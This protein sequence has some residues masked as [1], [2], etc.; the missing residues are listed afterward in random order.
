MNH[1]YRLI[2][3]DMR[4]AYVAVAEI[5]KRRG[6]RAGA[7]VR[8]AAAAIAI[9]GMPLSVYA[10]DTTALP[11]GAQ[12]VAGN[13][14]LNQ[15]GADLTVHQDSQRA[16]LNWTSFDIGSDASV[17]FEQ[18]NSSAVA[19]NRVLGGTTS[20]VLGKLSAN[21]Q[22][23][24][25]NPNGVYFGKGAQVDVGGLVASSLGISDSDFLAGRARFAAAGAAGAVRNEGTIRAQ[26][27]V[28]AMLAPVVGNAGTIRA[29]QVGLAAG[30]Q[31]AL[32]FDQDGLLS[33]AVEKGALQAQI[34][35]SGLIQGNAVLLSARGASA[36]H[37]SVIN[38]DGVIEATDLSA[39]GGRILLD[40]GDNGQVNVSGQ[41]DAS[42]ASGKGGRIDLLGDRLVLDGGARLD[43]SGALGGG[44]IHVGGGWQGH[45]ASLHNAT[46]VDVDN[47]VSV[48]ASASKRGDGGEVVFWSDGSTHFAGRIDITGGAQGGDGGRA[49]VSGKQDLAYSGRTDARATNGATGD[50]LLDPTTLTIQAGVGSGDITGSTVYVSDLEAQT[51]NVML[52]A[53]SGITVADLS[54][55]GGDGHLTMANNVSLRLEN[56]SGTI[57]FANKNNT[58][59][60]FGTG[61]IYMQS[62]RTGSGY[63][64]NVANLVAHGTGTNPATLPTHNVSTPGDGTPGAGSITLYGADGISVG[65]ALTTN[66]GYVRI[67]GDSDNMG[68]GDLTLNSP[69]NTNGGNLYL[70]TGSGAVTLNSDMLL[71]AGRIFFKADG[72]YTTGDKVLNGLLSASGDVNIDTAFTMGGN[73]SIYTDGNINFGAVNVN[74]NTGSGVLVL[75]ANAIDWGSATLQNLSTASMRLEPYDASTSMVLGD[76]SGFAS[77]ATLNKLPGIKNLTIGREDGTGTISVSGDYSFNATGSFE[78]VNRNVDI[79]LGSLSTTGDVILTGDNINIGKA[80]TAR[81]GAGKVTIRQSTASNEL[82]LGSGLSNA[83]IGEV[84]A[85]TLEVG[86]SDGGNLVFDSD[87]STGATTVH[88][89]SGGQVI[90]V[91][92]G[93][94][95]ASLAI[96]AGGGATISDDTFDFTTLGLDVGGDSTITS[97]SSN[98]SLGAVDGLAGLSIQS[99]KTATVALKARDTLGL[100]SSIDFA[101]SGST[102]QATA[103][104]GFGAGSV[105]LGHQSNATVT[106]ALDNS[107]TFSLGGT[108]TVLSSAALTRFNGLDTLNVAAGDID[109]TVDDFDVSVGNR[110][111]IDAGT[112]Q[113][114]GDMQVDTGSLYLNVDQGGLQLDHAVT[115]AQTV[116]LNDTA[117]AGIQGSGVI[118]ADALALR[119]RG[120]VDLDASTHQVGRIAADVGSLSFTNGRTLSV[121]SVDGLDGIE[122]TGAVDVRAAGA[123]S[124]LVLNNAVHAGNSG[125]AQTAVLL[126]AGRNFINHVGATAVSADQGRWLVYSTSPLNDTRGGLAAEFKQYDAG[127]ADTVLDNGSGFLYTVAPTIGVT[128]TGSADKVYDGTDAASSDDIGLSLNGA[129]D[130]D[131]VV[132]NKGTSHYDDKN[133]GSGKTVTMDGLDIGGTSNGSVR[134]Y[135]YTLAS[136]SASGAIGTVT[137]KTI[138]LGAG[139][140]QDKIYDGTT[141]AQLAGS[142][143]LD[144]VI[145]SDSVS[146]DTGSVTFADRNAGTGKLVNVTGVSLAGTDAGNYAV[147]GAT[148]ADIDRRTVTV[149]VAVQDKVY[150]GTTDASLASV[151]PNNLIAGDKVWLDAQAA[152]T[153]KNVGDNKNVVVSATLSGDDAGNYVLDATTANPRASTA[154]ITPKMIDAGTLSVAGKVYDGNRDATV[155]STGPVGVVGGDD[156]S[157]DLTGL[158]DDKNA[159]TGKHVDVSLGLSGGDAGNYRLA[160]TTASSTGDI[161]PKTIDAGTLSVAG[162]VYDGNR[163]ATVHSTGPVGVVGGDDLSLDLTG[164]YDNKN[165]GTGKHVDVSLGLSGGDAGNYRLGSTTASSTG[166]ITRKT[167]DAGTLSVA[168]KVYDGNRDATVHSTGLVGVVGGDDLSLDLT[169]LYDDKN[170]GTGKHVDVSLGLSGGDAGNYQLASTTA[171]STGDITPKSIDAGTVAVVDKRFDG[172]GDATLVL[173]P[174]QGLVDGDDVALQGQG[175]FDTSGTGANKTVQIALSLSGTDAGNYA[176]VN[177]HQQAVAG[178]SDLPGRNAVDAISQSSLGG[179]GTQPG[180]SDTA[181]G[182]SPGAIAAS[183]GAMGDLAGSAQPHLGASSLDPAAVGGVDG[184]GSG[185]AATG[186]GA[187]TLASGGQGA[188]NA[189]A[190]SNG[191]ANDAGHDGAGDGD[192]SDAAGTSAS[193]RDAGDA[194]M[195]QMLRNGDGVTI[196]L[197]GDALAKPRITILPVFTEEGQT[198]DRFRVDDLGDS[199]ALHSV[200]GERDAAPSLEQPVRLRASTQVKVGEKET[201]SLHMELLQDGTLHVVASANAAKLGRDALVAYSLSALRRQAGI[202]PQQV[203]A[204]VLGFTR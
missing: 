156:L 79:S 12:V 117:G 67:W 57:N 168:G 24:L 56:T 84:D 71:G 30:D 195:D 115:A 61:S 3:D 192:A 164:L 55:N 138:S 19:L 178:I 60:V 21:G 182:T 190:N 47:S 107:A 36:L 13:V 124:D 201:A 26:G 11:S 29:D 7:I 80:V 49:E 102:L 4:G 167:I 72:S 106:F 6:K 39:Q 62:G 97:A 152:F 35:Q 177:A 89:K 148:Y 1:T 118:T 16:I 191:V 185:S 88:L 40:G 198:V 133:V 48:D 65:G 163:G 125:A 17:R 14:Q 82:H 140:V 137:K 111:Q 188:D 173:P 132:V 123:S 93:V 159:G 162:K 175:Q 174:L 126:A 45:D 23:W 43:A 160:S 20:Q 169:G 78:L 109:V 53:D 91:A 151:S 121:G 131:T 94:S 193:G 100:G 69:I 204:L 150:D 187:G 85:A 27:G 32:D 157:L 42:S 2:W 76:A 179:N 101:D 66:G 170:A 38:M 59:E 129:I 197:V 64:T 183:T 202:H 127:T 77:A 176:L 74:L 153:D 108:G 135:G 139:S 147:D 8:A 58:I 50:L 165:A 96:T 158:Y 120:T 146:F 98:W 41:L 70:S 203:H 128:L 149:G 87:I 68:G 200:S 172:N 9:G 161:T 99:G 103:G 81:S 155:H 28:V 196:S 112:L 141:A 10:T 143:T 31:V 83:S 92:G 46:R 37:S 63:L 105:V 54:L 22:V 134:V 95:A 181:A 186:A 51:A 73:A 25:V 142:V 104:K 116:A 90:G 86:R 166:D 44:A 52:Q 194:T 145:G 171:S 180:T 136:T 184:G 34:A 113:Q 122:A 110:M 114:L 189:R 199:L 154:S 5:A 18:P 15:H 75:R 130:G 144:G 119:S 33:L